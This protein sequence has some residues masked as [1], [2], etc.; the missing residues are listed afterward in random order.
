MSTVQEIFYN[1]Y[2]EGKHKKHRKAS[3][4]N[5]IKEKLEDY[6]E[7][8]KIIE[9]INEIENIE[10][11]EMILE[12]IR[13]M[14]SNN[15]EEEVEI[16]EKLIVTPLS[17]R[18]SL[19]KSE[20][21]RLIQQ[22]TEKLEHEGKKLEHVI[23]E[24]IKHLEEIISIKNHKMKASLLSDFKKYLE[25]DFIN[26]IKKEILEELRQDI[27]KDLRQEIKKIDPFVKKFRGDILERLEAIKVTEKKIKKRPII[28]VEENDNGDGD[29]DGCVIA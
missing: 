1:V 4:V 24:K 7:E 27:K 11:K 2:V 28:V 6:L 22:E 17:M 12:K 10:E 8:E 25:E 19:T 3:I 21:K 9:I 26:N 18:Q 14:I 5:S 20:G 16:E 15:E 13:E 23:K 29:E